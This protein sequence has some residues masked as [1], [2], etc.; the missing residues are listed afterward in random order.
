[1]FA[2]IFDIFIKPLVFIYDIVFSIVYKVYETFFNGGKVDYVIPII[3]VSIIVN[4]LTYPLYKRAEII[5]TIDRKK[6]AEMKD[7]IAN[8]KKAF[9]GNEQV[10][11]LSTFYRQHNY[12]FYYQL[13]GSISLLLQIPFF[14]GAYSFFTSPNLL[15]GQGGLLVSNSFIINDLSK[16]DNLLLYR[17]ININILPIIMT[18]INIISSIIYTKGLKTSDKIQPFVLAVIFFIFLYNSP[19]G[20]VIYWTANNVI[21]LIKIILFKFKQNNESNNQKISKIQFKISDIYILL[22]NV[23]SIAALLGF[24]IPIRSILSN[25]SQYI[26]WA[27]SFWSYI[28][29][30]AITFLGLGLWITVFYFLSTEK[31]KKLIIFVTYFVLL[32]CLINYFIFYQANGA[33]SEFLKFIDRPL[34]INNLL[35]IINSIIIVLITI[36]MFIT[37][38]RNIINKFYDFSKITLLLFCI[39]IIFIVFQNRRR[40]SIKSFKKYTSEIMIERIN[41]ESANKGWQRLLNEGKEDITIYDLEDNDLYPVKP[42]YRF[43]K[44]GKNV[45]LIVLSKFQ[46]KNFRYAIDKN[47]ELR[48]MYVGFTYYPNTISFGSNVMYGSPGVFGGYEYTPYYHDNVRSDITLVENQNEAISLLPMMFD[49]EGFN[50]VVSN[51]PLE[52]YGYSARNAFY[53]DK[54]EKRIATKSNI[55]GRSTTKSILMNI[56]N[57]NYAIDRNF[58]YHS[59]MRVLPLAFQNKVYDDGKYMLPDANKKVF[60]GFNFLRRFGAIER[61]TDYSTIVE[62]DANNFSMIYNNSMALPNILS[63]PNYDIDIRSDDLSKNSVINEKEQQ[64]NDPVEYYYTASGLLAKL[65]KLFNFLREN[66]AYDNTK[67]V[68]TSDFG[69]ANYIDENQMLEYAYNDIERE[70]SMESYNPILLV[71]DFNSNED[72]KISEEFMTNADVPCLII[73]NT[74][75][76]NINP[77]TNIEINDDYKKNDMI[78]ALGNNSYLN[79]RYAPLYQ[80]NNIFWATIDKNNLFNKFAWTIIND[81]DIE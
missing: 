49:S 52:N 57:T 32:V 56:D 7:G 75:A 19:A 23:L 69:Y 51:I 25:P 4:I 58:V 11:M 45:L 6:Q 5:Q 73:K 29:I 66:E 80:N 31:G 34:E 16:P 55:I 53:S 47:I 39:V 27:R 79:R 28:Y 3:A 65:G 68:I 64:Y 50:S 46:S 81:E 9:K 13:A 77:Y 63:L 14:I 76:S 1:M 59:M 10:M 22:A 70:Y 12:K 21:S 38:K 62:N 40:F 36:V 18:I 74:L 8:I 71:K 17:G 20:L 78:V 37:Y 41:E 26:N 72:V 54:L 15:N 30:T 43:S 42:V 48:K 24:I 33:V 61:L 2:F 67:I 35:M 60:Y 44:Y